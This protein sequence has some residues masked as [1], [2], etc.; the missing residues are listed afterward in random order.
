MKAVGSKGICYSYLGVPAVGNG[1]FLPQKASKLGCNPKL[2]FK[3]LAEGTSV[4]LDNGT[5]VT[6]KEVTESPEPVQ[7]F[8]AVF[9]PDQSYAESFVIEN[10]ELLQRHAAKNLTSVVYHS[11]PM[12]CFMNPIY[13]KQIVA[14]FSQATHILDL[15]ESNK[16]EYARAKPLNYSNLINQI[17][18]L[19]M[20]V[21]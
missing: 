4:T 16:Q 15:P 18:P 12:E 14:T 1:K 20:P 7:A 6:G 19:L 2:H 3:I 9:L 10:I 8:I 11:M 13:R 5:V 21:S 17:C